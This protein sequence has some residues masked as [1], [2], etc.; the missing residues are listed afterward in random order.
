MSTPTPT[1]ATTVSS[2][3][4][5]RVLTLPNLI[6]FLRLLGV[7]LFLYLVLGP[8]ADVLALVVLMAS[9][10]TDFLDGWLEIGRAHV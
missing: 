1:P 6:S 9:G 10:V 5:R 8:E 3:A 2:V 7:P 4:A